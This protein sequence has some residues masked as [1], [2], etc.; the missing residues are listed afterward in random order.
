MVLGLVLKVVV[1]VLYRR[2]FIEKNGF[3]Y[4]PDFFLSGTVADFRVMFFGFRHKKIMIIVIIVS[5][6]ADLIQKKI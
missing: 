1:G 4:K 6:V 5:T 3:I 2:W